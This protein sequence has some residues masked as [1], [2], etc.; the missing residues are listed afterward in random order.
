MGLS[1][2]ALLTGPLLL[3]CLTIPVQ[4]GCYGHTGDHGGTGSSERAYHH[5]DV[6]CHDANGGLQGYYGPSSWKGFCADRIWFSIDNLNG[7][8]G[9]DLNDDDCER[10]MNNVVTSCSQNRGGDLEYLWGG[11][12]EKAGWKFR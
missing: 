12:F 9:F 5:I 6:S 3:S 1:A 10:E 7:N 11:E 2:L 8:A 4:A